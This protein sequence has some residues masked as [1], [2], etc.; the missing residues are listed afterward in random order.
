MTWNPL[1]ALSFHSLQVAT[2]S[3][4]KDGAV[5]RTSCLLRGGGRRSAWGWELLRGA[6]HASGF[7]IMRFVRLALPLGSFGCQKAQN[8][9]RGSII[10]TQCIFM[11]H[12][13][14]FLPHILM[15]FAVIYLSCS[16]V[17]TERLGTVP[18]TLGLGLNPSFNL[19]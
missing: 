3:S 14:V 15:N 9:V 6:Q 7:L 11:V 1:S 13:S 4:P 8:Q 16:S 19:H 18:A 17:L 2:E 10:P 12:T 5:H